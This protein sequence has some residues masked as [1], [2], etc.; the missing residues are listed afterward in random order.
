MA[1][2]RSK[3]CGIT[4]PED[5]RAA[6]ELGADAVGLVFYAKSKRAVTAAQ[7]KAVVAALPPFVS[8]VAL[9]V[10]ETAER[11]RAVL[12]EVPVDLIQFHG[13]EDDAFC[14][15]FGR[16]YLKA[17]RV[18]CAE[19]IQTASSRFP[20]AR[21][22]L[23]DAYHPDAYGGTGLSFDWSL[24]KNY[25]GKP[26]VLAGG[27]TAENVADAVCISGAAAVDVS[28]G[29][30]S[31]GGIKDESLLAAFLGALADSEGDR[32]C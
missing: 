22:I 10:N 18:K 3:I 20:N 32:G 26:W 31:A 13:D 23:F 2:I 7:A 27:L 6:A 8:V 29:V 5:A 11:I 21:A 19:D 17:V 1:K 12:R 9:F 24:L 15:Q 14:A 4:R 25:S 16:P 30:E 28:G